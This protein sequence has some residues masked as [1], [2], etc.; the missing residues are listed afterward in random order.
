[1]GK[2]DKAIADYAASLPMPESSLTLPVHAGKDTL[3]VLAAAPKRFKSGRPGWFA[4]GSV[5]VDGQKYQC[6]FSITRA[7]TDAEKKRLGI[8]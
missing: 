5:V 7:I 2:N 1:M 8:A 3:G 4:T 6:T